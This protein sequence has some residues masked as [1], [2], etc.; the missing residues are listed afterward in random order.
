MKGDGDDYTADVDNCKIIEYYLN[1][2][3]FK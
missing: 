3:R 1:T 2:L